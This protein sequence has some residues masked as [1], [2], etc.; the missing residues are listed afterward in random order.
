MPLFRFVFLMILSIILCSDGRAQ[1]FRSLREKWFDLASDT[2]TLDSLSIIPGSLL[3]NG[4]PADTNLCTLYP[5][6]SRLIWKNKPESSRVK[7]QYRVYPFA[8]SAAYFHKDIRSIRDDRGSFVANPFVYEAIQG[9][10]LLFDFGGLDYNGN[11]SRGVSFGSN[12][13]LVLNSAFN[14]QLSGMIARDLE[15]VAAITDNNVPFQP[16]GNTQQVQ[17]FDK[18]FIQLKRKQHAVTVGDF[19]L[20]NNGT[21]FLRYSKKPRG[22]LYQGSIPFKDNGKL[23]VMTAGGIMRGRFA[24]NFLRVSE[25]NQG[26]YKLSG[27]NGE[28]LII[29]LAN[30]E[31][32]FI[33]GE[34]MQRGADRDYVI[35][36][37]L[38]EVT[39]T[40][41]R[42]ITNNM[43]VTVEF[44]YTDRNYMR[45]TAM[46]A[47]TWEQKKYEISLNVYS[48]QDG[49]NQTTGGD[50]TGDRRKFL[51]SVG[52]S[53][54]SAFYRGWDT[55]AWDPNR[56]LYSMRDSILPN[57]LFIDS[58]FEYSTSPETGKYAVTFSLV[59]QGKGDYV[60]AANLANGRVYQWVAPV[61]DSLTGKI[62]PQGTYAPV[63]LLVSPKM[64]QMYTLGG[65]YRINP[66]HQLQAE[67]ALSYQD[68]NI[69]SPK[70]NS[71]NAGTGLH[72]AYK[73]SS[74]VG[75]DSICSGELLM[76]AQFEFRQNRFQPIE[77]YR[78]VE[79][80]RD[81]NTGLTDAPLNEYLSQ[82]ELA[83]RMKKSG[84]V[85]ARIVSFIRGNI[86]KGFQYSIFSNLNPG[87][88]LIRMNHRLMQS[89]GP[90]EKS[91]F[92]RP[93][94]DISY[95]I[96]K[97]A[98]LR[99]G[100]TLNHEINARRNLVF[101]TL[102]GSSFLWQNYSFYL[103]HGDSMGNNYGITAELRYEHRP[104]GQSFGKP[105]FRGRTA[106]AYGQFNTLKN[107][108]IQFTMTYRRADGIDS[109]GSE[110]SPRNFYLGRLNYSLSGW[111]GLIR[112]TTFYE[113]GSGRQQKIQLSFQPSPTNQGDYIWKDA[114]GDGIKQIDEFVISQ[115]KEDTSYFRIFTTVPE[116]IAVN[117]TMFN[118][119]IQ[120]NPSSYI[121]D[122]RGWK[123]LLR[124]FSLFGSVQLNK[125]V[126]AL[127]GKK[128]RDYFNPIPLKRED[129]DLV[130]LQI[131]SRNTLFCNKM[132]PDF[133]FQI[134]YN[135]NNS[136]TLLTSGFENRLSWNTGFLS[137]WNI[138]KAISWQQTYNYGRKSNR[139]DFYRQQQFNFSFHQANT[140]WTYQHKSNWR[141]SLIY[142]VAWKQNP[143]TD[144]AIIQDA[145]QHKFQITGR[146]NRL[147]KSTIEASFAYAS[148]RY[149]DFGV[150][151]QQLEYAMLEGLRNGNNLVWNLTFEQ[152]LT[153]A[154]QLL[155]SYD[156]RKTGNTGVV[157]TGRAELRAMF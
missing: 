85:G 36:Y 122:I 112:S 2:L 64:E 126:F 133:G 18:L 118:Q 31:E 132:D 149:R 77:R 26:P 33:N 95:G 40:P 75:K 4:L 102:I 16:E 87:S 90:A 125:K 120:I 37:N 7:I 65:I 3:I 83:Y 108:Q 88:W 123:G 155:L 154:V 141:I 9:N 121:R 97:L 52:D 111:T 107:Q 92:A 53:I 61:W 20:Y 68:I 60:P 1:E 119:I 139:S 103:K 35:D 142:D 101:D 117:Q 146:Y 21:Y 116:F 109:A 17:E 30:S 136:R 157:H 48:E 105:A 41:Q 106:T 11:F 25:G 54:Q 94:A 27:A 49:K 13:D 144:T 99:A 10:S 47:F 89:S 14:L 148:V 134:D 34:K 129:S 72:F 22:G 110:V 50:L 38:G 58:I 19:D 63:I 44:E 74:V 67:V 15:V 39:F 131:S 51:E 156:G 145:L 24:R 113:I 151:N 153:G 104:E 56:V 62:L 124:R 140:D 98:G 73:G 28:S 127:S 70:D 57:G 150:I 147:N 8:F 32:I 42:L 12:Q 84:T 29:I 138:N 82:A 23:S 59:G 81:W 96:K 86:Y 55:V 91:L 78:Q 128:V 93:E 152:R 80:A 43:R 71:D 114:N 100:I 6:S 69:L 130:S 66:R 137:R 79:F 45:S 143:L 115:F 5:W 76:A 46:G 135:Y